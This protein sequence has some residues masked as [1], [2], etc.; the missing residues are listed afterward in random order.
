[1]KFKTHTEIKVRKQDEQVR[2]E[3]FGLPPLNPFLKL[4]H[5]QNLTYTELARLSHIDRKALER[6][7]HGTYSMPLPSLAD[8]WVNQGLITHGLLSNEYS[9]YV[10][11][12]RARHMHYFGP[13]LLVNV[14]SDIHPFRQ[15]RA[16]RP[17]LANALPLPVG[18]VEVSKALCVP[19]DTIQFFERRIQQQSVPKPLK[20]ALNQVGYSAHA[21]RGF[22]NDYLAW[23]ETTTAQN[24]VTFA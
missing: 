10:D 19:L 20:A 11:L 21:L 3:R 22:E 16:R 6:A 8:Y 1:M 4:R 14:S 15:L 13:T 9:D 17:S 7:E 24:R 12:Q 2:S 18:I 23:R 5:A